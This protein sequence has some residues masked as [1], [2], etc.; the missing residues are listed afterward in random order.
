MSTVIGRGTLRPV[1]PPDERAPAD[2]WLPRGSGPPPRRATENGG[3]DARQ[4]LTTPDA[5]DLP[6][7]S[8]V[9]AE[10]KHPPA[11]N[12]SPAERA[13]PVE[14]ERMIAEIARLAGELEAK[15]RQLQ[16]EFPAEPEPNRWAAPPP[17]IG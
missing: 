14:S 13:T 17:T 8:H 5:A 12:R 6:S 15:L 11:L 10:R 3:A 2:A 9:P 1:T 4:W 7:E 16:A